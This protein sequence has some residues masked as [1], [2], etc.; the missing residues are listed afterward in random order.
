MKIILKGVVKTLWWSFF[1]N[2][3]NIVSNKELININIMTLETSFVSFFLSIY[4]YGTCT[5]PF[6]PRRHTT[7]KRRLSIGFFYF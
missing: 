2:I 3:I 5:C 4:D 7:L 6:L 1:A